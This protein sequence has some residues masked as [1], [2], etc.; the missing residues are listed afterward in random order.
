[1]QHFKK[2]RMAKSSQ[3]CMHQ[4]DTNVYLIPS[5]PRCRCYLLAQ[6]QPRSWKQMES[7]NLN[8]IILTT[9]ICGE[10]GQD[11]MPAFQGV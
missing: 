1:M 3:E 5:E 7:L 11:H 8:V 4:C 10:I 2:V 9:A 6:P